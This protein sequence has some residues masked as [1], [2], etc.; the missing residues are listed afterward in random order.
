[1][2]QKSN[3]PKRI[4]ALGTISFILGAALTFMSLSSSPES[5]AATLDGFKP[6]NII[7]DATMSNHTSMSVTDIQNFLTSKNPCKNTDYNFYLNLVKKYPHLSWHWSGEPYNGHFVCLSEERFGDGTTIGTGQ[8]AA[9]I[10]YEAAQTHRINPQVLLVLL[11]KE[12]SLIT[13]DYPNNIQYRSA[14]GYGCPDTA[15]CDSK[16]YGLK[17]QI[18]KAAELFR[19]TLDHGYYVYPE[20]TR[21][22]YVAYHPNKS[23]GSSEVWIENRATAALYRYTPYQPN[24][25]AINAGTGTGDACS[26]YGNRNFYIFFTRWFGSTQGSALPAIKIDIPSVAADYEFRFSGHVQDVDWQESAYAGQ[27]IGSVGASLRLEAYKIDSQD[28]LYKSDVE[29]NGWEGNWRTNNEISGTT[30]ASKRIHAVS[31]K[32]SDRLAHEYDIYYRVHVS[33]IGWMNWAKNGD[34]AG[35]N[36]PTA[37]VEALQITV[38]RKNST[39]PSGSGDAYINQKVEEKPQEPEA[40]RTPS[41]DGIEYRAHVE[42]EFWQPWVKNGALAGTTGKSRRMEALEI[43][44]IGEDAD[45][46]NIEYRTHVAEDGWQPWV[47][48]GAL[49]GT[50]G[51][52]LRVEAIEIKLTGEAAEHYDIEYRAHVEDEDWQPWVKNGAL[53]GTTGKSRRM[54]A[55][56]I[57]I[58]KK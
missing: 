22:V 47:K 36:I 26:A 7:S 6:G 20:K 28:I 55:L 33:D 30:G 58:V 24:T 42:D 34:P 11:E 41:I 9:E 49:S 23:C 40:P 18:N 48:N 13:D 25:A 15:A 44:L 52:S 4:I 45:K 12:Q 37:S 38:L 57:R 19:Y 27:P 16:Y 35:T 56:E 54:E 17:N 8:T 10:I 43:K 21:G 46:Y 31:M 50:T 3:I 53:A 51:R 2:S 14:T 32:L 29:S 39:A 1:M 5:S